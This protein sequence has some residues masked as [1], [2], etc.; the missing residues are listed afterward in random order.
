MSGLITYREAKK[1]L[2]QDGIVCGEASRL[3][4]DQVYRLTGGNK[5]V[6]RDHV[7]SIAAKFERKLT[8]AN[9]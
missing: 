7:L 5:L 8:E 9:S 4:L 3:A 1:I 2:T 6:A